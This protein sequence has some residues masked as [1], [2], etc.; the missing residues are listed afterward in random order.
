[1]GKCGI[2]NVFKEE[3]MFP[4][5]KGYEGMILSNHSGIRAKT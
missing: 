1:M 5:G 2:T 3:Q 4:I